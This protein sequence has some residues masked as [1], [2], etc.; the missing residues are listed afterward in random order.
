MLIKEAITIYT[1]IVGKCGI[2]STHLTLPLLENYF[3]SRKVIE[4]EIAKT[5]TDF[6]L[7][8]VFVLHSGERVHMSKYISK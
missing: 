6:S 5:L 2:G 1:N 4:N 3:E 7:N 8:G